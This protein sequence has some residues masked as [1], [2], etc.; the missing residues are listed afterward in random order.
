MTVALGADLS[1]ARGRVTAVLAEA[2]RAKLEAR[3]LQRSLNATRTELGA[4]DRELRSLGSSRAVL[5]RRLGRLTAELRDQVELVATKNA[6]IRDLERRLEEAQTAAERLERQLE[7]VT[8][9]RAQ[10]ESELALQARRLE[11]ERQAVREE[12]RVAE[13]YKKGL[14][15]ASRRLTVT[16]NRQQANEQHS[17]VLGRQTAAA[18]EREEDMR[19]QV[20]HG[21]DLNSMNWL[22]ARR[23]PTQ[24]L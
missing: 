16:K 9:A 24:T 21:D 23:D 22:L 6:Y 18:V 7:G 3:Q 11:A 5:G 17:M 15:E 1:K 20:E 2:G 4:R 8:R 13:S 12:R 19:D 10:L 14:V